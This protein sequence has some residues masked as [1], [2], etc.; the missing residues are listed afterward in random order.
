MKSS[1]DYK[2]RAE[3]FTCEVA[4]ERIDGWMVWGKVKSERAGLRD[5]S[6]IYGERRRDTGDTRRGLK[7]T[8]GV[9]IIRFRQGGAHS[10]MYW[11]WK[12]AFTLS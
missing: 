5:S 9:R 12:L 3:E 6:I 11:P 2:N 1:V 10:F 7:A 4:A 8:K